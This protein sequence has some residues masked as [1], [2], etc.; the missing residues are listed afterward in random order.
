MIFFEIC[1]NKVTA[2]TSESLRKS[3]ERRQSIR[4]ICTWFTVCLLTNNPAEMAGS[5]YKIE[6]LV[7]WTQKLK[8]LAA[9]SLGLKTFDDKH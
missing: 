3:L 8:G 7:S 9:A 6:I 5:R 2:Y 1:L 4:N